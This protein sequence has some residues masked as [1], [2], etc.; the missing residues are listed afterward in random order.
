M[1]LSLSLSLGKV[2]FPL[3]D[4][5]SE[6]SG[7]RL[8]LAVYNRR[9]FNLMKTFTFQNGD[10]IPLLGLGL[11]REY[12][13]VDGSFWTRVGSPYTLANLWD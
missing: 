5:C 3:Y 4:R 6:G 11:D 10:R 2:G 12:R 9:R 13:Y 7:V 8:K 1:I